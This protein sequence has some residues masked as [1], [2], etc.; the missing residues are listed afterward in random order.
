MDMPKV[1]ITGTSKGVGLRLAELFIADGWCVY[2]CSRTKSALIH[3]DYRHTIVDLSDVNQAGTWIKD[4]YSDAQ[5]I[6]LVIGNAAILG[7]GLAFFQTDQELLECIT[8]NF[9]SPCRI[10][11]DYT[12]LA[13]IKSAR[14]IAFSSVAVEMLDSGTSAYSCSK[15][16]LEAYVRVFAREQ[17]KTKARFYVVRIPII[18]AGASERISDVSLRRVLDRVPLNRQATVEELFA[19]L[20]FLANDDANYLSGTV[21]PFG[22]S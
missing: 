1:A 13:G 3:A 2:G 20:S 8:V 16:A 5:H 7:S 22:I 6:D 9:L 11:R 12:R 19:L 18:S 17:G 10:F 4:V 14:F 21:I 15:A